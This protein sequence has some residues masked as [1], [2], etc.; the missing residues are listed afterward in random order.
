MWG[1]HAG[2]FEAHPVSSDRSIK[3]LNILK[4]KN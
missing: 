2:L 1:G 4:N 3:K